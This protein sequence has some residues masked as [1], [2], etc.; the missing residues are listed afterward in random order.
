M[1]EQNTRIVV[2]GAPKADKQFETL[3]T[4][5]S[6]AQAE[7]TDAQRE[8]QRMEREIKRALRG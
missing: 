3:S 5:R 4:E 1:P 7:M 8:A 2:V 6:K